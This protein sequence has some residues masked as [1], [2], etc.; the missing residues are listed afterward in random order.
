MEGRAVGQAELVRFQDHC[1]DLSTDSVSLL[2]QGSLLFFS[3]IRTGNRSGN[4]VAS[5]S[6]FSIGVG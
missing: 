3:K 1:S 5:L 6:Q 2:T 4:P